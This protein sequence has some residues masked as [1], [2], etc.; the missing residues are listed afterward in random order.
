MRLEIHD[1][2]FHLWTGLR[3][4]GETEVRVNESLLSLG[5]LDG[6]VDEENIVRY[7]QV[8]ER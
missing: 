4:G 6:V 3:N 1:H 8:E 5:W 2:R 7:E